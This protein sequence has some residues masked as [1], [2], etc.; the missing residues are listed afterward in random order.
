MKVKPITVI[1]TIISL[2][3]LIL[4][5]TRVDLNQAWQRFQ[6]LSLSFVILALLYYTGCQWLSCWRWQIILKANGYFVPMRSLLS[7]YFAGMFLNSFLPSSIGGDVYRVY[8]I[9][10]IA[11]EPEVAF[12]S[13]FL[14]R[15]TGLIA[16]LAIGIIGLPPA[17]K[18]I[19]SWDIILL[20][21]ICTGALAGAVMLMVSSKLLVFL[22]PLF[23]KLRLKGL[24]ARFAK[25]QLLLVQ[26]AQHRC[27]LALSMGL[28]FILQLLIIYYYYLVAQQLKIPI[29]FLELLVFVPIIVVVTLLPISLGGLGL[30]EG[31]VG[32]LFVRIGLTVEQALLLSIT[33]TALGWLLSLP[34]GLILLFDSAGWQQYLNAKKIDSTKGR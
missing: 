21:I 15:I 25:I 16:I 34:G 24:I 31:L 2:G 28:S 6:H 22:E 20:L 4:V 12:V 9:S 1:K 30:R 14:E 33:I 26:F 27:P 32:Y 23:L 18:L 29:S 10:Q 7:S 13:V 8:Q 11:K 3:L 17:F 19:G 5:L